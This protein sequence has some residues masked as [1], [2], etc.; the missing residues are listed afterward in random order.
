[1]KKLVFRQSAIDQISAPDKT[2]D[3]LTVT[4]PKDWLALGAIGLLLATALVWGTRGRI[5]K[6][7]DGQGVLVMEGGVMN[8]FAEGGG[9]V[10][11]L[12]AKAGD[13]VQANQVIATLSQPALEDKIKALRESLADLER[14]SRRSSD[15][16]SQGLR[17]EKSALQNQRDN[18]RRDRTDQEQQIRILNEQLQVE[19]EL[20]RKGLITRQQLLATQQRRNTA[21][22]AIAS[23]DAQMKQLDLTQ[24]RG[25]AQATMADSDAGAKI[26]DLQRSI[27]LLEKELAQVSFVRSQ[28]TGKIL[29]VK[30]YPGAIL[31]N[32]EPIASV[33]PV[34]ETVE[35]I[36]Y[37]PSTKVKEVAP[38]MLVEVSPA[39]V[40]REEYGFIRGKVTSVSEFP[41]T[42]A[43]ITRNFENDALVNALSAS[44]PV[45]EV[46]I[47]L[48]RNASTRSGFQ[49]SSSM[50]PAT[51]ITSGTLCSASIV[52]RSQ[53][54]LSLVIPILKQST[55]W[56]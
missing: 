22:S 24:F 32:G 17:L 37:V 10:R 13:R 49:W 28:Y 33:E 40:Q 51:R 11:S 6:K 16:R 27:Q 8:I 38:G 54:P 9:R 50:G 42:R 29:E 20:L 25:E 12:Q 41:A 4:Q 1:M 2:D 48:E 19:E 53:T 31:S 36:L 5:Y 52:T 43:R 14:E 30:S 56:N 23:I 35:V 18:L 44:G 21:Q 47:A 46:R 39:S 15:A 55:G 45:N 3:V 7:V 26:G 34:I